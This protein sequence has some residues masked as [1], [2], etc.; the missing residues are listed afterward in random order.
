[1]IG[2]L[3]AVAGIGVAALVLA[4]AG[5]ADRL[6][7]PHRITSPTARPARP[8]PPG[9]PEQRQPAPVQPSGEM[10]RPYGYDNGVMID[11]PGPEED[12]CGTS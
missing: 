10:T 11:A 8:V 12:S 4:I 5:L 6:P 7:L 2:I 3:Q 1:M 9:T